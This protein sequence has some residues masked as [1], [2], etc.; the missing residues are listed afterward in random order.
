MFTIIA[1]TT[2]SIT[3]LYSKS[4]SLY[5]LAFAIIVNFL[6]LG[7][8]P[9]YIDGK[10]VNGLVF[11]SFSSLMISMYWSSVVFQ[12]LTKKLDFIKSNALSLILA[13]VIDGSIM[14]IFFIVNNKFSHSRVLDIFSREVSYKIAYI[15]AASFVIH[16]FVK[17]F[18]NRDSLSHN[19]GR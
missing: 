18:K 15:L 16:L 14:G 10:I 13:S 12:K 1:I 4:K 7:K 6:F 3:S 8:I 11:A 9:Y 17:M 19:L 2:N 5:A